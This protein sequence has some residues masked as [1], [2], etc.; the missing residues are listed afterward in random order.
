M[1]ECCVCITDDG[2]TIDD[3]TTH[4]HTA[5]LGVCRCV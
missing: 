1:C 3:T 4:Q 5:G 2:V